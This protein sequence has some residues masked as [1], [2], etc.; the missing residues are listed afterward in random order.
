[1][2][3]E[4]RQNNSSIKIIMLTAHTET[5]KLLIAVELKLTKYLIKPI[6][7]KEFKETMKILAKELTL[8]PSSLIHL[9]PSCLW[10]KEQEVLTINNIYIPLSQKEHKLFKL[11]IKSKS[12]TITYEDIM[13]HVWDDMLEQDISLDS[14]KN[15]VSKLR[16]KLP[17]NSIKSVYGQGYVLF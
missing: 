3:K 10:D 4:V 15:Q 7:P 14:V 6:A 9:D 13:V 8:N 16:K 12:C 17:A 11:F 1:V 2:A 5:E